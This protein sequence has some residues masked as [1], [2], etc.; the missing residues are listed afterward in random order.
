MHSEVT[1]LC[2][3]LS[4]ETAGILHS[5]LFGLLVYVEI[6]LIGGLIVTIIA[7]IFNF[8]MN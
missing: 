4:T 2:E 8:L 6:T 7:L 5:Q 3:L 1:L